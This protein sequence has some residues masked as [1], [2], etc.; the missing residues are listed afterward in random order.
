[1]ATL[2]PTTRI[3]R[4]IRSALAR[5][6]RQL[7]LY[8]LLEGLLVGANWLGIMFWLGLAID[9]L[10]VLCGASE[11]PW[12]AR[13][14][15]LVLVVA[16]FLLIV[17]RWIVRRIVVRMPDRSMALLL[18]RQFGEFR[19]SLVTAVELSAD[20][21]FDTPRAQEMLSTSQQQA[22]QQLQGVRTGQVFNWMPLLR[23][24]CFLSVLGCSLLVLAYSSTNSFQL[25]LQRLYLL[26]DQTWPRR[27]QITIDGFQDRKLKIAR[28]SDFTLRV[29]ANT[30]KYV[31]DYCTVYYY[32]EQGDSGWVHMRRRGHEFEGRQEFI[33]DG[34]PFKSVLSSIQFD[35]LG[36]DHRVQGYQLQVVESPSLTDVQLDCVFPEYL[37]DETLGIYLPRTERLTPGT[38]LPVGTQIQIL[39]SS[40]K[41]LERVELTNTLTDTVEEWLASS[42]EEAPTEF[43]YEISNLQEDVSLAVTLHDTDGVYNKQPF[44]I[45]V[46][47]VPDALPQITI[48]MQGIGSAITPQAVIPVAGTISDDNAVDRAW[49]HLVL[50]D[51]PVM[52]EE[53]PNASAADATTPVTVHEDRIPIAL[54]PGTAQQQ[55]LDLRERLRDPES[56]FRLEPGQRIAITVRAADFYNLDDT[57]RVGTSELFDLEVVT[58]DQL[59]SRLETAEITLRRRLQ[60]V[61]EDL[62]TTRESLARVQSPPG[63][64]DSNR[65]GAEP[66]DKP[67]EQENQRNQSLR[68]LRVQRAAQDISRSQEEVNGIALAFDDIRAELVNNRVDTTE[69][70]KHLQQNISKPLKNVVTDRYPPVVQTLQTL[71][72]L[73]DDPVQSAS[74]AGTAIEQLD[75]ILLD[76]EGILKQILDLESYNELIDIVRSIITDQERLIDAT[77]KQLDTQ[78][79]DLLK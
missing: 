36:F 26:S 57:A 6:R 41:P 76:L 20:K 70:I 61:V 12:G 13:C 42:D 59:I 38:R 34:T 60:Q 44:R 63:P 14:F 75:K 8:V 45:L 28:G 40:D 18:E 29:F 15:L 1:M 43:A 22:L 35:V 27:T 2:N 5:L 58:A 65:D 71:E 25:A 56:K 67:L 49:F 74:I 19:D 30:A 55:R 39:A 16:V 64:S 10:P 62:H 69:R 24:S 66:D 3:A 48:R 32:T 77:E 17:I 46:G 73:L 72:P 68:L 79:I 47:V 23:K 11:M 31:P 9:Y 21:T 50:V 51:Q 4:P 33:Y 7:R 53:A 52:Q 37:V 78:G 54:Q